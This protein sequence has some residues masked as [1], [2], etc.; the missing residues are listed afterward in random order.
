MRRANSGSLSTSSLA[1][2]L[3][4]ARAVD[5]SDDSTFFLYIF[6][7][8]TVL[9]HLSTRCLNP[10]IRILK[11]HVTSGGNYDVCVELVTTDSLN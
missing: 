2:E 1:V 9:L 5:I 10:T 3:T 6:Q 8:V 11:I 7:G 4:D